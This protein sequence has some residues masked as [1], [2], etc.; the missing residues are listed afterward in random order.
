M[1]SRWYCAGFIKQKERLAIQHL[2]YQDYEVFCPRFRKTVSHARR[3]RSVLTPLFPGYLFVRLDIDSQR[4]RPI[5]GTIGVTH[6]IRNGARP[7]PVPE[8]FV[9]ALLR[10]ADG[11]GI[12]SFE[13]SL[14]AGDKV[15]TIGGPFNGQI[16]TL[17]KL[18]DADRVVVLMSMLGGPVPVT[19]PRGQLMK[20]SFA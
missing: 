7:T 1:A 17:L 10:G 20:A 16:G 13:E 4:W 2:E 18:K 8:S 3:T 19:V 14:S 11:D 15:Q 12:V 5:D 9:E 6:I